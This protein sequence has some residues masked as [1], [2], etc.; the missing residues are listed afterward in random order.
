MKHPK[1]FKPSGRACYYFNYTDRQGKRRRRST[2]ATRRENADDEIRRF[3][4]NLVG[5]GRSGV[6]FA[7]YSMPYFI[8]EI[9]PRVSRRLKEGKQIGRTH[10]RKSRALLDAW[11][12][13]DALF[14]AL[15]ISKIIRG[16][17]LDL[18]D[19]LMGKM[20]VNTLNKTIAAVKTVLSEASFRG[21]IPTDPGARVGNISYE[22]RERGVFTIGEVRGILALD[23]GDMADPCMRAA[24]TMLF[25][26]GMRVGELRA[27]HWEDIS[28]QGRVKIARAFKNSRE[29]G[30]PK[31]DKPREIVLPRLMRDRLLE[32]GADD[33]FVFGDVLGR[34]LGIEG[35]KN[36]FARILD[37]ATKARPKW[38]TP[39]DRWLTP[40]SCRHTLNTALLAAG[41]SP[42]LVQTYLGWS[43]QEARILTRVQAQYSHLELLRLEDVAEK[44]DEL[45]GA[46]QVTSI[47]SASM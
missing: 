43:S 11:I 14:S 45:Y 21:D 40:H 9:C 46:A 33:T 6:T 35:L 24:I 3:M 31:W 5:P 30:G 7:Q 22:Q 38:F 4:S 25:C 27:L 23:G 19:R 36:A 41:I 1:A 44:I 42:L 10:V 34:S 17:I 29:I 26:T 8:W 37:V 2:S 18:R 39:C 20:G 13:K 15:P 47:S 16:D 32:R 28:E 12:M